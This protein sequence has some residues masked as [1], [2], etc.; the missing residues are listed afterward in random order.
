M[1]G[2][3]PQICRNRLWQLEHNIF[4]HSAAKFSILIDQKVFIHFPGF[5]GISDYLARVEGVS[6]LSAIFQQS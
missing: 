3:E 4:N 5:L 1:L 2:V 6:S